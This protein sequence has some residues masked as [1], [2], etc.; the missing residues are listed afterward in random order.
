MQWFQNGKCPGLDVSC[1][2]N[3]GVIGVFVNQNHGSE[4]KNTWRPWHIWKTNSRWVVKTWDALNWETTL[5]GFVRRAAKIWAIADSNISKDNNCGRSDL[6]YDTILVLTDI[7]V[8]FWNN[9]AETTKCM[10]RTCDE[11]RGRSR[12]WQ[13]HHFLINTK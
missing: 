7:F 13:M 12:F 3:W 9:N 10:R 6:W 1:G 2:K 4:Y 5:G 8:Q 11:S